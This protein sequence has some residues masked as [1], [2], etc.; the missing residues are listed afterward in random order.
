M[1]HRLPEIKESDTTRTHAAPIDAQA[2]ARELHVS[3]SGEVR[4]DAGSR[5]LY[6]TDGSNYRQV[7][8]GIVIPKNA[9]DVIQTVAL[10]R[11]Y[12]APL[13]SR[14]GGTSLAGQTCNTAVIVDMSRYMRNI[15]EI[16]PEQKIARIQ[17]GIVLDR[18]Y[19][20]RYAV[21]GLSLRSARLSP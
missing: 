4:F 18:P 6:A 19:L 11:R 7:P 12:H 17:P 5:A 16:N 20:L 8:I 21:Q 3:I 2:L 1:R 15:L 13:L 14:G 10:C 9:E